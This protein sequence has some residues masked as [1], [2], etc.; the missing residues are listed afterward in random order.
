MDKGRLM[1]M[2]ILISLLS[3]EFPVL[4]VARIH[5]TELFPVEPGAVSVGKMRSTTLRL[6][7]RRREGDYIYTEHGSAFGVDLSAHGLPTPRYLLTAAHCVLSPK[8]NLCPGGEL[9]VELAPPK[10]EYAQPAPA[11]S[12]EAMRIEEGTSKAS[13]V[14]L[15]A[16]PEDIFRYDGTWAKCEVLAVDRKK[17]LCLLRCESDVPVLS[18]LECK[19]TEPDAG[20]A[21]MV[22]GCPSGVLPKASPG[23]LKRKDAAEYDSLWMAEADFDHGNSGGPV[24]RKDDG[25]F[26]GLAVAGIPDAFG[27]FDHRFALFVPSRTVLEFVKRCAPRP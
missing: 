20:L 18:R 25:A 19:H 11:A 23:T 24:Y 22:I 16:L 21:L 4:T 7:M 2:M 26:L 15:D 3:M 1:W 8:G 14:D 12:A 5:A 9:L 27:R 17:D 13:V 10:C 6:R